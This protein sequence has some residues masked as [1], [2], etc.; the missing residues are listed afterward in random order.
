M[1]A[2]DPVPSAWSAAGQRSSS[3]T[4]TC[5]VFSVGAWDTGQSLRP[6]APFRQRRPSGDMGKRTNDLPCYIYHCHVFIY[7]VLLRRASQLRARPLALFLFFFFWLFN[8]GH[9][10]LLTS[11]CVSI[12]FTRW[13]LPPALSFRPSLSSPS[14]F[15]WPF[16]LP[17]SLTPHHFSPI[18]PAGGVA[19]KW[20]ISPQ[21]ELNVEAGWA[22]VDFVK[23]LINGRR[24]GDCQLTSF[25]LSLRREARLMRV[26]L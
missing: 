15:H 26:S 4:P 9:L 16:T 22:L 19:L 7:R 14:P 12:S 10:G 3:S 2:F 17:T 8:Y 13:F 24:V 20:L 21:S 1:P 18:V 6:V 11:P 25:R 23:L 5:P